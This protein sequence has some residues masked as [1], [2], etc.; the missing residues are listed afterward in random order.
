MTPNLFLIAHRVRGEP[1]FDIAERM[2]APE[3]GTLSDPAPWWIMP[4]T[5][6]RVYPF[7]HY[8]PIGPEPTVDGPYFSIDMCVPFPPMPPSH[9][10]LYELNEM[11]D[12]STP[13]PDRLDAPSLLLALGLIKPKQTIRRRL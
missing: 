4:T 5:G 13:I 3:W 12:P 1:T 8:G 9:P 2:D 6:W 11:F 7:W 10:D